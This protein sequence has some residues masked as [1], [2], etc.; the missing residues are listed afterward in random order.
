MA[1]DGFAFLLLKY[2]VAPEHLQII[3]EGIIEDV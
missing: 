2:K 1:R 3:R